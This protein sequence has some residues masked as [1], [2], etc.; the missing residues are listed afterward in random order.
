M[1]STLSKDNS[2]SDLNDLLGTSRESSSLGFRSIEKSKIML[3]SM[4]SAIV[5]KQCFR[6]RAVSSLPNCINSLKNSNV[7]YR[8][9]LFSRRLSEKIT[10]M[11]VCY[12]KNSKNNNQ[13]CV[14][15]LTSF[16]KFLRGFSGG[17]SNEEEDIAREKP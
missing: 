17:R 2:K 5:V 11:N 15:V 7:S 1:N 3:R 8:L 10:K 16:E 14:L 6:G 12:S 13:K 9:S 4:I